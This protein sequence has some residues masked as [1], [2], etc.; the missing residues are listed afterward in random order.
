MF[1]RQQISANRFLRG[2]VRLL[3]AH[4]LKIGMGEM[5]VEDFNDLL[6][7]QVCAQ[8]SRGHI[9]RILRRACLPH[10]SE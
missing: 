6:T 4:V 9:C 2:M 8:A 5:S 1:L 3:V 10:E 7:S